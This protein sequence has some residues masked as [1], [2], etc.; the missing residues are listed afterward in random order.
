MAIGYE[1]H[2]KGLDQ[3]IEANLRRMRPSKL[4][5]GGR[6]GDLRQHDGSN[7]T[8]NYL[9]LPSPCTRFCDSKLAA[10]I[11]RKFTRWPTCCRCEPAY[12]ESDKLR[13]SSPVT[14]G[15][16]LDAVDVQMPE[17]EQTDPHAR[18]YRSGTDR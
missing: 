12:P 1:C 7:Q 17:N 18:R 14:G 5:R 4:T 16:F 15:G 11:G 9:I 2:E 13:P 3:G 6:G 8:N 10:A